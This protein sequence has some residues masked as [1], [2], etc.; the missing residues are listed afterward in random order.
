MTNR[1][2]NHDSSAPRAIPETARTET[3]SAGSATPTA[4]KPGSAKPGSAK[5]GPEKHGT[6]KR[7]GPAGTS[8]L[9]CSGIAASITFGVAGFLGFTNQPA[10]ASES[11]TASAVDNGGTASFEPIALSDQTVA[12]IVVAQRRIHIIKALPASAQ[13][14][15]ALVP[16]TV[17]ASKAVSTSA[18]RQFN[19]K[20]ATRRTTTPKLTPQMKRAA[21]ALRSVAPI[22]PV[23]A[24]AKTQTRRTPKRQVAPAPKPRRAKTKAS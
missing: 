13:A 6:A 3:P 5:L 20:A 4:T 17:V 1:N 23:R 19:P 22:S 11:E 18:K 24:V 14:A 15:P 21:P 7:K 8:K 12:P 10:T 9:I 16:E 2:L